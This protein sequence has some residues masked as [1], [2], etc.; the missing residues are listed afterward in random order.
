[1]WYLGAVPLLLL[2]LAALTRRTY[3][4]P[5]LIE[6][7]TSCHDHPTRAEV[8]PHHWFVVPDP[9]GTAW[10]AYL[11]G[12]LLDSRLCPGHAHT[13]TVSYTARNGAPDKRRALLTSTLG[14]VHSPS[15]QDWELGYFR[16]P[17]C[18]N[19]II[20]APHSNTLPGYIEPD[21]EIFSSYDVQLRLPCNA[22]GRTV[23]L[24]S[25]SA[26]HECLTN[27][28]YSNVMPP[29]APRQLV[30]F[31]MDPP[32]L[33]T[34][35]QPPAPPAACEVSTLGYA[36]SKALGKVIV[37]WTIGGSV[38]PSNKC[39]GTGSSDIIS[40]TQQ[41]QQE[42]GKLV[43]FAVEAAVGGYVSLGFPENAARMYDADVILGWVNADGRGVVNTYHV[44]SYEMT[45]ADVGVLKYSWAV[46]PEDGLVEHPA[47]GFG[48]GL[49]DLRSG[50]VTELDVVSNRRRAA[51][52]A[53][54]VLMTIAW[55][56]LLPI[57]AM[58]PAH[59]WLFDGRQVGGKALWYWT[60]IGM[61]LGGF[62]TFAVGF[63]LA[64]AYFRR[65]GSSDSL[66][67]THAAIGYV[68]AGL[69]A[70]QVILAFVRPD[71]GTK[72][73]EFVW[74]PVHKLGGRACTLVAWCAVLTGIVLHRDM[75]YRGP[76]VPWVVP[77]AIVMG[78]ILLVDSWLR[79]LGAHRL[80]APVAVTKAGAVAAGTGMPYLPAIQVAAPGNGFGTASDRMAGRFGVGTLDASAAMQMPPPVSSEPKSRGTVAPAV[81]SGMS[82]SSSGVS[83]SGQTAIQVAVGPD[84]P[85]HMR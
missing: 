6:D 81:R 56:L 40:K 59:R 45:A 20:L 13:I 12:E 72:M 3:S 26:T 58:V 52:L 25:S 55:V 34:P 14:T 17:R 76:V 39:T 66:H 67:F 32:S 44:T 38:P 54:G 5:D 16:D 23:V 79:D 85:S 15:G 77:V 65:P 62:G 35:P 73:R 68:V 53:H 29:Y 37:H 10:T 50:V 36:C 33:P 74:N 30:D 18:E 24:K 42:L 43:H 51:V 57:G 31:M 27:C 84:H 21:E 19:R 8:Y 4:Y 1:M 71:P 22:A 48:G 63:V 75:V 64:M 60:H 61:Q 80:A 82:T 47:D 49:V 46:S 78:L 83:S 9:I 2:Q 7:F 70:L 28:G 69:A 41:Q 11:G